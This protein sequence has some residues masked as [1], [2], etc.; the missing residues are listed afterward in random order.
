MR[1]DEILK[2]RVTTDRVNLGM[3][4]MR[5]ASKA[6]ALKTTVTTMNQYAQGGHFKDA[7]EVAEEGANRLSVLAKEIEE[8]ANINAL[9]DPAKGGIIPGT[10]T[11]A[12][13]KAIENLKQS[14][15]EKKAESDKK[16]KATAPKNTA[17][18]KAAPTMPT[19]KGK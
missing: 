6:A 15:D 13:K 8:L 4:K 18:L 9:P 7:S 19:K 16:K 10:E 12:Q 1:K 5:I 3:E 2:A 11:P 14:A 17:N